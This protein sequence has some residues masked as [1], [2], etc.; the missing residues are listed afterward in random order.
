MVIY[1]RYPIICVRKTNDRDY[2]HFLKPQ[3][4]GRRKHGATSST[5]GDQAPHP[6]TGVLHVSIAGQVPGVEFGCTW[7]EAN[8]NIYETP[9]EYDDKN[10]RI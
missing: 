6:E 1:G 2:S 3:R 10:K 4:N 9:L 7:I 8:G 5:R